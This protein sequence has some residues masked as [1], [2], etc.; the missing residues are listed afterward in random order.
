MANLFDNLFS[1]IKDTKE[2]EKNGSKICAHEQN[3]PKYDRQKSDFHGNAKVA[4]GMPSSAVSAPHPST[5]VAGGGQVPPPVIRG[6]SAS[7]S[8]QGASKR[9]NSA[10]HGRRRDVSSRDLYS[11]NVDVENVRLDKDKED[12]G[13]F[14]DYQDLDIDTLKKFTIPKR[15]KVKKGLFEE[16]TL[17]S[18]EFKNE[19]LPIIQQNFKDRGGSTQAFK[20]QS[21]QLVHNQ[22]IMDEYQEKRKEMRVDGY[23]EKETADSYAFLLV[24]DQ[25][26]LH[27][28]CKEGIRAGN[29]T[30]SCIGDATKGVTLCRFSDILKPFTLTTG[31]KGNLVIFRVMKGKVKPMVENRGE[32]PLDPTP[33]FDCHI[34]KT[35]S[36]DP[37]QVGMKQA[38]ESAQLYIYEYDEDFEPKAR[39]RQICQYAVLQFQYVPTSEPKPLKSVIK[40]SPVSRP[41]VSVPKPAAAPKEVQCTESEGYV[42]WSG[43]LKNK[44]ALT[45]Y[46]ELV[47]FNNAVRPAKISD[48]ILIN[49][50]F[51]LSVLE[52]RFLGN[53][54][55]LVKGNEK[56]YNGKFYNCCDIRPQK[57]DETNLK[58]LVKFLEVKKKFLI[59]KLEEDVTI[60][61]IPDC[62]V[63]VKVGLPSTKLP[64]IS[65]HCIF[66]SPRMS[67]LAAS[68]AQPVLSSP[69]QSYGGGFD[70]LSSPLLTSPGDSSPMTPQTPN[71]FHH[72]LTPQSMWNTPV[73]H[74]GSPQVTLPS[75]Y[76]ISYEGVQPYGSLLQQATDH[77]MD[78]RTA[79]DVD[80][81]AFYDVPFA[82]Q[83]RIGFSPAGSVYHDH[84]RDQSPS[85]EDS[86][87]SRLGPERQYDHHGRATS[88]ASTK[89][90]RQ[91]SRPP[92][93]P[94]PGERGLLPTPG[95]RGLL[96]TPGDRDKKIHDL[97]QSKA[98]SSSADP[99]LLA[100]V[101]KLSAGKIDNQEAISQITKI[102]T[103]PPNSQPPSQA[104]ARPFRDQVHPPCPEPPVGQHDVDLREPPKPTRVTAMG[105]D[106]PDDGY[107]FDMPRLAVL[108]K[109]ALSNTF[110]A[111]RHVQDKRNFELVRYPGGNIRG[112]KVSYLGFMPLFTPRVPGRDGPPSGASKGTISPSGAANAKEPWGTQISGKK[113]GRDP[114][115]RQSLGSGSEGP[116]SAG[117]QPSVASTASGTGLTSAVPPQAA[118]Q[119][120][121]GTSQPL[122]NLLIEDILPTAT[123][124]SILQ[125]FNPGQFKPEAST[126]LKLASLKDKSGGSSPVDDQAL[127]ERDLY[128][129]DPNSRSSS[130]NDMPYLEEHEEEEEK[131]A[132][133]KPKTGF[134]STYTP[135]DIEKHF[136]SPKTQ[137]ILTG[138][139]SPYSTSS[140]PQQTSIT[141]SSQSTPTMPLS[142]KLD[143]VLDSGGRSA[144]DL[145]KSLLQKL[146]I[147][148]V[149]GAEP[150]KPTD[151][152]SVLVKQSKSAFELSRATVQ[153]PPPTPVSA[154]TAKSHEQLETQVQVSDKAKADQG[155]EKPTTAT[156]AIGSPASIDI[157]YEMEDDDAP[158]KSVESMKSFLN[159]DVD[160]TEKL[161]L[162]L[163]AGIKRKADDEPPEAVPSKVHK[164]ILETSDQGAKLTQDLPTENIPICQPGGTASGIHDETIQRIPAVTGT[165][166]SK[167]VHAEP[168]QASIASDAAALPGTAVPSPLPR[169]T[170]SAEP[171][172]GLAADTKT[173]TDAEASVQQ[174]PVTLIPTAKI[175]TEKD[176]TMGTMGNH[177]NS[178]HSSDKYCSFISKI[179]REHGNFEGNYLLK[180]GLDL[181]LRKLSKFHGVACGTSL[182][183]VKVEFRWNPVAERL[184]NNRMTRHQLIEVGLTNALHKSLGRYKRGEL[185]EMEKINEES[186]KKVLHR[187]K[188]RPERKVAVAKSPVTNK[189]KGQKSLSAPKSAS[190]APL[191]SPVATDKPMGQSQAVPKVGQDELGQNNV[192]KHSKQDTSIDLSNSGAIRNNEPNSVVQ[193]TESAVVSPMPGQNIEGLA[194]PVPA[195]GFVSLSQYIPMKG[196]T[197]LTS[198]AQ[199]AYSGAAT[200]PC[201][202]GASSESTGESSHQDSQNQPPRKKNKLGE[203]NNNGEKP[204]KLKQ[205]PVDHVPILTHDLSAHHI[206]SS[207]SFAN[208]QKSLKKKAGIKLVL[209]SSLPTDSSEKT[210]SDPAVTSS[211]SR[212]PTV[213]TPVE[214]VHYF[215]PGSAIPV[216]SNRTALSQAPSVP[217]VT[218]LPVTSVPVTH[219]VFTIPTLGSTPKKI[220]A[221]DVSTVASSAITVISSNS[222]PSVSWQSQP[223]VGNL[224]S[225]PRA[226]DVPTEAVAS[227]GKAQ[228]EFI[229][230]GLSR[231]G[232]QMKIDIQTE[233]RSQSKTADSTSTVPATTCSE[234]EIKTEPPGKRYMYTCLA[235]S[236]EYRLEKNLEYHFDSTGHGKRHKN[237]KSAKVLESS[238][239]V[240][241][242]VK[243]EPQSIVGT[244]KSEPRDAAPS[245]SKPGAKLQCGFC[246]NTFKNSDELLKHREN[247][248]HSVPDVSTVRKIEDEAT[249]R[250]EEQKKAK[251][252][253]KLKKIADK[254]TA[255]T[256]RKTN[257]KPSS[258]S[259]SSSSQPTASKSSSQSSSKSDKKEFSCGVCENAYESE[260]DLK[261]HAESSGHEPSSGSSHHQQDKASRYHPYGRSSETSSKSITRTPFVSYQNLKELTSDMTTPQYKWK[262][263]QGER[264]LVKEDSKGARFKDVKFVR[265][266]EDPESRSKFDLESLNEPDKDEE[267]VDERPADFEERKTQTALLAEIME[268]D[269]D[270]DRESVVDAGNSSKDG[271][272]W[273]GDD[274]P[275][276]DKK[277]LKVI[278]MKPPNERILEPE[279]YSFEVERTTQ[280]YAA[281]LRGG[282]LG[283]PPKHPELPADFPPEPL[284][285]RPPEPPADTPEELDDDAFSGEVAEPVPELEQ[286]SGVLFRSLSVP[287]PSAAEKEDNKHLVRSMSVAEGERRKGYRLH[288]I[289]V[290]LREKVYEANQDV[291]ADTLLESKVNTDQ[292]PRRQKKD[293][294]KPKFNV[295]DCWKKVDLKSPLLSNLVIT[296]TRGDNEDDE[297]DEDEIPQFAPIIKMEP[298]EEAELFDS[299]MGLDDCLSRDNE[300]RPQEEQM[301]P[302]LFSPQLDPQIPAGPS[303]PT[304]FPLEV[305]VRTPQ[306][307]MNQFVVNTSYWDSQHQL[308]PAGGRQDIGQLGVRPGPLVDPRSRLPNPSPNMGVPFSRS[309]IK[310]EPPMPSGA[311]CAAPNTEIQHA[312]N[313]LKQCGLDLPPS[314]MTMLWSSLQ[315]DNQP[316]NEPNCR[317]GQGST[318]NENIPSSISNIASHIPGIGNLNMTPFVDTAVYPTPVSSG[319]GGY[320][321][322]EAS[323]DESSKG[324]YT[325]SQQPIVFDYQHSSVKGYQERGTPPRFRADQTSPRRRNSREGH[326]PRDL[327]SPRS[328][329]GDNFLN[330][331]AF[332]SEEMSR[333]HS[334]HSAG[335][336]SRHDSS[337]GHSRSDASPS[338]SGLK[339]S[340]SPRRPNREESSSSRSGRNQSPRLSSRRESSPS[341]PGRNSSPRQSRNELSPSRTRRNSSPRKSSPRE[342]SP[343]RPGRNSSPRQYNRRESSAGR[344]GRNSPHPSSRKDSKLSLLESKNRERNPERKDFDAN[345]TGR[346][347][348][349]KQSSKDHSPS[350]KKD[351]SPGHS[352]TVS[353]RQ[354][355]RDESSPG[356]SGKN[357]DRIKESL[358]VTVS[359]TG[360][361]TPLLD[362]TDDDVLI[363]Q[364]SDTVIRPSRGFQSGDTVVVQQSDSI[365]IEQA[366][367]NDDVIIVQRTH[368][369]DDVIITPATSFTSAVRQVDCE[370]VVVIQ[371]SGNVRLEPARVSDGDIIV[372]KK[373]DVA[374]M[375]QERGQTDNETGGN[376]QSDSSKPGQ[377]NKNRYDVIIIGESPEKEPK[378]A[379]SMPGSPIKFAARKKM[380]AMKAFIAKTKQREDTKKLEETKKEAKKKE[381]IKLDKS[382]GTVKSE[383][384]RFRQMERAVLSK[385][386]YNFN[387][388]NIGALGKALSGDECKAHLFQLRTPLAEDAR[389]L[390]EINKVL[391]SAYEKFDEE[392]VKN[393]L[394]S[395]TFEIDAMKSQAIGLDSSLSDCLY[396]S[397]ISSTNTS[398]EKKAVSKR[399][400]DDFTVSPHF[401]PLHSLFKKDLT[402]SLG[403][404]P[405][406]SVTQGVLKEIYDKL[407]RCGSLGST[408]ESVKEEA[409]QNWENEYGSLASDPDYWC[410]K[411]KMPE[412]ITPHLRPLILCPK[413]R[414]D[415]IDGI[416]KT[417]QGEIFNTLLKLSDLAFEDVDHTEAI[418]WEQEIPSPIRAS[419]IKSSR[420]GSY[421]LNMPIGQQFLAPHSLSTP[422]A[423]PLGPTAESI[424]NAVI[425]LTEEAESLLQPLKIDTGPTFD[426][427]PDLM[428]SPSDPTQDSPTKKYSSHYLREDS[429]VKKPRRFRE[430]PQAKMHHETSTTRRFRESPKAR[431]HRELSPQRKGPKEDRRVKRMLAD[432]D[433]YSK[434]EHVE[435]SSSESDIVKPSVET[436]DDDLGISDSSLPSYSPEQKVE[437]PDTSAVV[438]G[439]S[440]ALY[441]IAMMN[442]DQKHES[443]ESESDLLS[444]IEMAIAESLQPP[445][446][447]VRTHAKRKRSSQ[448][449]GNAVDDITD[450]D[451]IVGSD[452]DSESDSDTFARP[453]ASKPIGEEKEPVMKPAS[454]AERSTEGKPLRQFKPVATEVKPDPNDMFSVEEPEFTP[455]VSITKSG[456]TDESTVTCHDTKLADTTEALT[457]SST[458]DSSFKEVDQ[459]GE[460][461]RILPAKFK[462]DFKP[463]KDQTASPE[464]Q[465]FTEEV[466]ED[467]PD[468]I[469][470]KSPELGDM[471]KMRYPNLTAQDQSQ[472]RGNRGRGYF[473]K[474]GGR[475]AHDMDAEERK[476]RRAAAEAK[477][478]LIDDYMEFDI[479]KHADVVEE[480]KSVTC[481]NAGTLKS[482]PMKGKNLLL[483]AF[484]QMV[485]TKKPAGLAELGKH[486]ENVKGFSAT[487]SIDTTDGGVPGCNIF[488][489]EQGQDRTS[490]SMKPGD[491]PLPG[492][493][494]AKDRSAETLRYHHSHSCSP[495]KESQEDT[496]TSIKEHTCR[497]SP[498][499]LG[500]SKSPVRHS[501]E[502]SS[503][504]K[505]RARMLLEKERLEITGS[506]A[507]SAPPKTRA[508]MLLELERLEGQEPGSSLQRRGS[509][510]A[511]ASSNATTRRSSREVLSPSYWTPADEHLE[512]KSHDR[513]NRCFRSRR[514]YK[515]EGTLDRPPRYAGDDD[516]LQRQGSVTEKSSQISYSPGS[517]RRRRSRRSPSS[518]SDS[519]GRSRQVIDGAKSK[520]IQ[521]FDDSL[522]SLFGLNL[523]SGSSRRSTQTAEDSTPK[524]THLHALSEMSLSLYNKHG[525]VTIHDTTPCESDVSDWASTPEHSAYSVGSEDNVSSSSSFDSDTDVSMSET[526]EQKKVTESEEKP[527]ERSQERS[528]KSRTP[529]TDSIEK[530]KEHEDIEILMHARKVLGDH[531]VLSPSKVAPLKREQVPCTSLIESPIKKKCKDLP[532]VE[533]VVSALVDDVEE[534]GGE[535]NTS[536]RAQ[537][538]KRQRVFL[539]RKGFD[540]ASDSGNGDEPDGGSISTSATELEPAAGKSDYLNTDP[541][542]NK[543]AESELIG[544]SRS[545]SIHTPSLPSGGDKPGE[546]S[547]S[548]SVPVKFGSPCPASCTSRNVVH[549]SLQQHDSRSKTP[550]RITGKHSRSR[551]DSRSRSGSRSK[552]SKRQSSRRSRS[553][554][555]R[556]SVSR[557]SR[558]RSPRHYKSRRS[559]SQSP[560]YNKSRRSRSPQR[561]ASRR[562][563]S[564]RRYSTRRSR[565]PPSRSRSQS[566]RHHSSRS[567]S[568]NRSRSPGQGSRTQSPG[569]LK[570]LRDC[571]SIDPYDYHARPE[572]PYYQ[573]TSGNISKDST[574]PGE[575]YSTGVKVDVTKSIEMMLKAEKE[576]CAAKQ[577]AATPPVY[578]TISTASS[579]SE[580]LEDGEICDDSDDGVADDPKTKSAVAGKR[581]M[582]STS[583]SMSRHSNYHHSSSG[584]RRK[585]EHSSHRNERE[586]KDSDGRY[587]SRFGTRRGKRGGR[588]RSSTEGSE[589]PSSSSRS[590]TGKDST[591]ISTRR[592]SGERAKRSSVDDAKVVHSPARNE[593]IKITITNEVHQPQPPS[594]IKFSFRK[595]ATKLEQQKSSGYWDAETSQDSPETASASIKIERNE[596]QY[597]MTRSSQ[598]NSEVAGS[599]METTGTESVKH[600][601]PIR[602][603]TNLKVDKMALKSVDGRRSSDLVKLMGSPRD[604]AVHETNTNPAK[605]QRIQ[606]KSPESDQPKTYAYVCNTIDDTADLVKQQ[607]TSQNIQLFDPYNIQSLYPKDVTTEI[608]VFI[609]EEDIPRANL[610][611]NLLVLKKDP[612]VVFCPYTD[613]SEIQ[614]GTYR[615]GALFSQGGMVVPDE[616]IL[617]DCS[618]DHLK[619][620]LEDMLE[621]Q[622]C[623]NE[624]SVKVHSQVIC[625]LAE[626]AK[627]N[628]AGIS[629]RARVILEL[630]T[631]YRNEG[632]VE[633]LAKHKCDMHPKP[634]Q[635]YLPCLL[636]LQRKHCSSYRF[637]I[638]LSDL[639]KITSAGAIKPFQR[640]A[641]GVVNLEEMLAEYFTQNQ[642][643]KQQKVTAPLSS[644]PAS[645]VDAMISDAVEIVHCNYT[646]L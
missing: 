66:I 500:M 67:R 551:S 206:T 374:V 643:K 402:S 27:Q 481:S 558:S 571:R 584:S 337:P 349:P 371:Q 378:G 366:K 121:T 512:G 82:G 329:R 143:S 426:A 89:V 535:R 541:V 530:D 429:W 563:K 547:E 330:M 369:S 266:T 616:D 476:R 141:T 432:I 638:M 548:K 248:G 430:S 372:G 392:M 175:K 166:E 608:L 348:S 533:K 72:P 258:S 513:F 5:V 216:L 630:L 600:G 292:D 25:I 504:P 21:A 411:A 302:D 29:V 19:I 461:T 123:L 270:D 388:M 278:G 6:R 342:S 528:E 381:P 170:D 144:S 122:G 341:R 536:K 181:P 138:F 271:S 188:A 2:D 469:P 595:K 498:R 201:G 249:K 233:P 237:L 57:G 189:G 619:S 555:S 485:Q 277:M 583:K 245:S 142:D 193:S 483:K 515:H 574:K 544:K 157:A 645:F 239:A 412:E 339:D 198:Q 360:S 205:E 85:S 596:S 453:T 234:A 109:S 286:S 396:D 459:I 108:K 63:T 340:S 506:E 96:P 37:S 440:H 137:S 191:K 93:L 172:T 383:M 611:P 132:P 221:V 73:S 52:S 538:T 539:R 69:T 256:N 165:T 119:H 90:K 106:F 309:L 379:V 439:K 282:I 493:K 284:G 211:V 377:E 387:T 505:T 386:N 220:T 646:P 405:V 276:E 457:G 557:R 465:R 501:D 625:K 4:I 566:P 575:S 204:E 215:A 80:Y 31:V 124:T 28:I 236:L 229:T 475:R 338:C 162:P 494:S 614:E 125:K 352:R 179:A 605:R 103:A 373:S 489:M 223:A 159:E 482:S 171:A 94:T 460:S 644:V 161:A 303:Q 361:S 455:K 585:N 331:S 391:L 213:T 308:G 438:R 83:P 257:K 559:R 397:Q 101:Y 568:R 70:S 615:R 112:S 313:L 359:S 102:V 318:P 470:R 351:L 242:I 136:N 299:R 225:I 36:I 431:V 88:S 197:P 519:R 177:A 572:G 545:L 251:E 246:W 305:N 253:Q 20:Y 526:E 254:V 510:P 407:N 492:M 202:V 382:H 259:S 444:Q 39:P 540:S 110:K 327:L 462:L 218:T 78:Y 192:P 508:R 524:S 117:V 401:R 274:D 502:L 433:G 128:N 247:T 347:P 298:K 81:R 627:N 133:P 320:P 537:K 581:A 406:D 635:E 294:C 65:L 62:D 46:V 9:D 140:A 10:G 562:S 336:S 47:T 365:R 269:D 280:S 368:P 8:S 400:H 100:L 255:L 550:P 343:S 287:D 55:S 345:R 228:P 363:I 578:D 43:I 527:K 496:F 577:A 624:W 450:S 560:R 384:D 364:T 641:I 306:P 285:D 413:R 350:G 207:D 168:S 434:W 618:P 84:G 190:L 435:V 58:R 403:E 187:I 260:K 32:I 514:S 552:F 275:L 16:L 7:S 180:S 272:D 203:S 40:P 164:P 51:P 436:D 154:V 437:L 34:S 186:V 354:S 632:I 232:V 589:K 357:S 115:F 176:D 380:E 45:C 315:G 554:S 150:V 217:V 209:S 212:T 208:F 570:K 325:C 77:D 591:S 49:T 199:M 463:G 428:Y 522:N 64:V 227:T 464:K 120:S 116:G 456:S 14:A 603:T 422:G 395:F 38:F 195:P 174:Q 3:V 471:L 467:N 98:S 323:Q 113:I 18:R 300:P 394:D 290:D 582:S 264:S 79:H 231:D 59:A 607:L 445:R 210:K 499:Q 241:A 145:A 291:T 576:K 214:N 344:E 466:V 509:S 334:S 375:V 262:R 587:Q 304:I 160:K 358:D 265:S 516:R 76:P 594:P 167:L 130:P 332:D 301:V 597:D 598:D 155:N 474:R 370:D 393:R 451:D 235:C 169:A 346:N 478:E 556:V 356:P 153:L 219:S 53:I 490:K 296:I 41:P 447:K 642:E 163:K 314:Q 307:D 185:S 520:E 184:N 592:Q 454:E 601:S 620:A 449:T 606:N 446:T 321:V 420:N 146:H 173:K 480:K 521:H 442:T 317:Q 293:Y 87:Y 74:E 23:S 367:D 604:D 114:R 586:R 579:F 267:I 311:H 590:E 415:E 333:S 507:G 61:L 628:E 529:E 118:R 238:T 423:L 602:R 549:Q 626:Q 441:S 564:P 385:T 479:D 312:L 593:I 511:S 99:K 111:E 565:S 408:I 503:A 353:P 281:L 240:P 569:Q 546:V 30:S 183:D 289:D 491:I 599:N 335:R 328:P 561:R 473:A 22:N 634:A 54:Y 621:Q 131:A 523:S 497:G 252:L 156:P 525:Q 425:D 273:S 613:V 518:E 612:Q 326:S 152:A 127:A 622:R 472:G 158:I 105:V 389:N 418:S 135:G 487:D 484:R 458:K 448:D 194:G 310:T 631:T 97:A 91:Y 261:C 414:L 417:V 399:L 452:T 230:P 15:Q 319:Y 196:I 200:T 588:P 48:E 427:L 610:I 573:Y 24:F 147:P 362:D 92:L 75:S 134:Y 44:Y 416:S 636:E 86:L 68:R 13:E 42:A 567:S 297:T 517:D 222:V 404:H 33:N 178:I 11:Q 224:K 12:R 639:N 580:E 390:G 531:R 288:R 50:S 104:A 355:R 56:K 226:M 398:P 468:P 410:P 486:Y 60:L 419:P 95:E 421:W 477:A 640:N 617:L 35:T 151:I 126:G 107:K 149:P 243:K 1:N 182:T 26:E 263:E 268:D 532:N 129:M 279:D 633:L 534:D 139:S 637:T 316:Q 609:L 148:V 322:S 543:H 409:L 283:R 17:T 376:S 295:E 495:T 488:C 250:G 71:V 629:K 244:I 324:K 424:K 553:R 542:P 443:S 623:G